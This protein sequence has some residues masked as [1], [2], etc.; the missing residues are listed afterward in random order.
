MTSASPPARRPQLQLVFTSLLRAD[1]L[2][3]VKRRRGFLLSAILPIVF[4]IL[5]NR[6]KASTRLGGN[7]FVIGLAITIGLVNAAII[8]YALNVARDRDQGVFQRLRVTPAPT[9]TIMTSRLVA[10]SLAN[11]LI[12][13]VAIIVGTRMH[14]LNPSVGEYALVLAVSVFGGAVFLAIGQALVGLLKSADTVNAG[15]RVLV[16][17]LIFGG[18]FAQSGE[19]GNTW[20][21]IARWSPVGAVITLFAGVLDLSIWNSRDS[22][23]VLACA[24]YI[25]VFTTLGIRW[26]HWDSR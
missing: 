10:N 1:L 9:W 5:L 24:G 17:V 18:L 16:I 6:Q 12:A 8:G 15:G 25:V 7:L 23:A 26:F 11:L 3:L 2:V 13:L 22:L 21:S 19:L 4:L 14:N 20:A